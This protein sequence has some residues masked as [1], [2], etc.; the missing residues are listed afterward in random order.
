M[1]AQR[2]PLKIIPTVKQ[3][4]AG[5]AIVAN[6]SLDKPESLHDVLKGVGYSEGTAIKP[7][8]VTGSQGFIAVMES[9]GVDDNKLAKVLDDGLDA[10]AH[11]KTEKVT[12]VGKSRIKTEEIVQVP[13]L[14][15]RHRY[16]ETALRIKGLGKQGDIN[17]NFNNQASEHR[18]VY[19]L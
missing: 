6:S 3:K 1:K 8:Q 9:L 19:D 18:K 11:L 14:N 16:L 2:K 5:E 7:I 15:I 17:F 13:D 4:K 10:K 12:G